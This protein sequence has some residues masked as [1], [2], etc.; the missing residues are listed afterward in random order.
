MMV[1]VGIFSITS[2]NKPI[3]HTYDFRVK[4]TSSDKIT[5]TYIKAFES[6]ENKKD[7]LPG[8]ESVLYSEATETNQKSVYDLYTDSVTYFRSISVLKTTTGVRTRNNMKARNEWNYNKID[9]NNATYL[10]SIDS[11]DF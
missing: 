9:E 2:C 1:I 10:L 6:V 11:F 4:N 5:V 7:I 3:T 8:D